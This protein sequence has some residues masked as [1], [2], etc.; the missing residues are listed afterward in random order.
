MIGAFNPILREKK[1]RDSIIA[2]IGKLIAI[3]Q[4]ELPS[5]REKKLKTVEVGYLSVYFHL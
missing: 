1:G 5:F 3:L 4:E 2:E